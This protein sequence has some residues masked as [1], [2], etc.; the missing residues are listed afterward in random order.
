MSKAFIYLPGID[1]C[2]PRLF[3]FGKNNDSTLWKDSEGKKQKYIA[4]GRV[5]LSGQN[6]LFYTNKV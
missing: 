4:Y 6:W 2:G 1:K 5:F 3:Y